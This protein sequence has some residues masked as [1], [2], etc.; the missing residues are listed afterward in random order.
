MENS[1]QGTVLKKEN[2]FIS[3][4]GKENHGFGIESVTKC[5]ERYRGDIE[6]E[7]NEKNFKVYMMLYG[8]AK[9]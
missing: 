9:L 8:D 7:I 3:T 1:Y 5:V 2:K 6:F 4:K